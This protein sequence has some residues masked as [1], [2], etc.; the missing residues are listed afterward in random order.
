MSDS[1]HRILLLESSPAARRQL[2]DRLAGEG[3][4]LCEAG[5]L[6]EARPLIGRRRFDLVLLARELLDGDGL[7]LVDLVRRGERAP[8]RSD[9]DLPMIVISSRATERDRLSAFDRGADDHISRPF[10]YPELVRRIQVHLRRTGLAAPSRLCVGQLE[11]DT[12]S[13]RAWV[14]GQAVHLS[15]KE[16]NLLRVLARDPQR[17]FTR[18]ELMQAVWGWPDPDEIRTRTVDSHACRLRRKL[19]GSGERF[20]VN[21][22]GIGY[23]LM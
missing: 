5:S 22:W 15:R 21:A 19:S 11:L 6:G 4:E 12:L 16:F 3:F 7:A 2:A 17:V 14:R 20:V 18:G 13:R 8:G 23:S 9:P 1:Q 10:S